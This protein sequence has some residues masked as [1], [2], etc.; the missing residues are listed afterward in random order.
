M[1][2]WGTILLGYGIVF[3]T[4]IVYAWTIVSRG[5]ALGRDLGLGES[6]TEDHPS[7]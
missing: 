5:R 7:D 3:G 6:A 2:S 4:V 1:E